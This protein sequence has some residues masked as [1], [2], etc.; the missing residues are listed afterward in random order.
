MFKD[1]FLVLN[2]DCVLKLLEKPSVYK[3]STDELYEL[4][5]KGF[6]FLKRCASKKGQKI[7][8]RLNKFIKFCL[9]EKILGISAGPRPQKFF[10]KK[11]PRP[12]LRYLLL[13]LTDRCN[14]KCKH[15]YIG[16]PQ[17]KNLSF[18]AVKKILADFEKNQG[19]RLLVSGGEPLLHPNFWK[20]N[21]L[22]PKYKFRKILL[23]NGLLINKKHA[24]RLNFDEVQISLDGLEKGHEILRGTGTFKR[25]LKSITILQKRNTPVSVSTMMHSQNL[26]GFPELE[27]LLKKLGVAGWT[28]DIP[29]LTGRM[30]N[31]LSLAVPPKIGSQFL[32]YSFG[33]E[34]HL[35]FGKYACGVHLMAIMPDGR[36][37]KCGYFVSKKS[38]Q[39][40]IGL[41]KCFLKTKK[42]KLSELKKCR[43]C[44]FLLECRGGCRARAGSIIDKDPYL[45]YYNYSYLRGGDSLEN[46]KI[47]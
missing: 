36:T 31:Y 19:L 27:K 13:H 1:K 38:P 29:Y 21:R 26:D 7:P 6:D 47:C 16:Q 17:G 41:K 15:C 30:K 8:Q 12:S 33:G 28:V 4:N 44:R 9:K 40:K 2:N 5:Q 24:G 11:S 23:T 3:I 46:K 39:I 10:L 22:L 18:S 34:G 42:I 14:L 45:C 43:Q 35:P 25:A 20:I 32:K 37:D